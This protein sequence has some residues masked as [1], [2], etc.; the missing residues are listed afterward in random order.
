LEEALAHFLRPRFDCRKYKFGGH[1]FEPVEAKYITPIQPDHMNDRLALQNS[2][3]ND[4][5][6]AHL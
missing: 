6:R 5:K 1:D 3:D 4:A 2:A